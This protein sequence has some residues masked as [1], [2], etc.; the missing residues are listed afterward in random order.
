MNARIQTSL[1]HLPRR[2]RQGGAA[3][4]VGL[5]LLMVL[6]LLAVSGMNTSTVELQMAGNMQYAQ[7]AFQAAETGIEIAAGDPTIEIPMEP[8]IP[9]TEIPGAPADHY[10]VQVDCNSDNGKTPA[11]GASIGEYALYHY[12]VTSTGDSARGARAVHTQSFYF[13]SPDSGPC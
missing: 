6:T 3:L 7:N 5:I 12:D 10:E 9:R 13:L 4:V 1:L 8:A 11:P 2:S